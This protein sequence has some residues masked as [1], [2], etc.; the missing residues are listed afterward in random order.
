MTFDGDCYSGGGDGEIM[1][2]QK[3]FDQIR[4]TEEKARRSRCYVMFM[5]ASEK[6]LLYL[7]DPELNVASYYVLTHEVSLREEP[8][9]G[10]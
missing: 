8:S 4:L 10:P 2:I 5:K 6:V 1:S 9:L 3:H 7:E